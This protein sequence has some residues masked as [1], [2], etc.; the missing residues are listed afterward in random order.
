M[1]HA[2]TN[3]KIHTDTHTRIYSYVY[4]YI[5]TIASVC[6]YFMVLFITIS[7][8]IH[9]DRMSTISFQMLR[10]SMKSVT[11]LCAVHSVL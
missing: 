6:Y 8:K 4:M 9:N 2:V 10:Y 1:E 11:G 5:M 7:Y 3:K